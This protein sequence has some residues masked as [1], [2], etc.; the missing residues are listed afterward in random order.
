MP[1]ENIDGIVCGT[2]KVCMCI[3][4]SLCMHVYMCS[5]ISIHAAIA[6]TGKKRAAHTCS[7][8]LNLV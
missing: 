8:V 7:I 6:I 5:G 2:S 1:E 3:C 4:V